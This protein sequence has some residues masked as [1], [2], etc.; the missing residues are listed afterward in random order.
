MKR[1]SEEE[2]DPDKNPDAESADVQEPHS[3]ET[4]TTRTW[5][6]SPE[7]QESSDEG[8][9]LP[10]GLNAVE[11]E[12]PDEMFGT[13][14]EESSDDQPESEGD[15][16]P[17]AEEDTET[18]E[19]EEEETE[20]GDEMDD[21]AASEGWV[22]EF[23][24]QT[25]L[26]AEDEEEA[27]DKVR[28]MQRDL[29]GFSEFEHVLEQVPQAAQL[30]YNLAETADAEE[31]DP[32]DFY[33][34]AQDVEGIQV[35]AP[36]KNESPDEWADFKAKLREKQQKM[37]RNREQQQERQQA[38][39]EIQEDFEQAFQS[40]KKRKGKEALEASP[41]DSFEEFKQDYARTFY[42]DPEKGELPRMDVFDVAW[43][44]LVGQKE[45]E[46]DVPDE[47][48]PKYKKGFNDAIEQMKGGGADGLPDLKGGAGTGDDSGETGS[49]SAVPDML[50]PGADEGGM[51]HDQ[52]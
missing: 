28:R 25:G 37:K 17:E 20:E 48:H 19:G 45:S 47:E 43:D 12:I 18:P 50:A 15:D 4:E 6:T 26:D 24:K 30:I 16:T 51:N 49:E 21:V 10:E 14:G 33:L 32:V 27:V 36:D 35:Q 41:Y 44:A 29:R 2:Y 31:I 38:A 11:G 46:N 42:G 39:Q 22:E 52:F 1:L 7:E 23:T 40:F 8:S 5:T 3:E 34:A 13:T 9:L